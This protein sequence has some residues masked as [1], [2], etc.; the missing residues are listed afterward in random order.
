M[1]LGTEEKKKVY[2]LGV[3]GLIAMGAVVVVPFVAWSLVP[4]GKDDEA[5]QLLLEKVLLAI[6]AWLTG[7]L[8]QPRFRDGHP[9]ACGQE[10]QVFLDRRRQMQQRQEL[11][12]AGG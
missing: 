2:A 9:L 8:T 3:L 6:P 7:N 11:A 4:K 5:G 10:Q 1:K 12:Y